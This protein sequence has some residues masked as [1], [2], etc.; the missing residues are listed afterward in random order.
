[1]KRESIFTFF[2][3]CPKHRGN[4]TI[5]FHIFT[6]ARFDSY[7][8]ILGP[9][10]TQ[11]GRV[12]HHLRITGVLFGGCFFFPGQFVFVKGYRQKQKASWRWRRLPT[13]FEKI[14]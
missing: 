6:I 11:L 8:P 1:M 12:R 10:K 13:I 3:V 5:T 7:F 2:N 9:N 4:W 14:M